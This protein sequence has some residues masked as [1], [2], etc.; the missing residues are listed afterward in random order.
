M[1]EVPA[2][3]HPGPIDPDVLTR[4]HEHRSG[5]IWSGDHETCINDLQ[6][7]NFGRNLFQAHST[8]PCRLIEII[9][10]TG[11]GGVFRYGYIG[12]DHTLIN[13]LIGGAL[14]LLQTWAWSYILVLHP[15]LDRHVELE[16]LGP[17]G[18]MWCT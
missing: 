3:V 6:C 15:Q 8:A 14:V 13:A 18:A 12:L 1:E 7:R 5:L 10:K 4:Q 9:D 2:H 16:P 17:L 11:L